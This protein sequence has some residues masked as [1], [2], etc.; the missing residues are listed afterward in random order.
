MTST[1]VNWRQTPSKKHVYIVYHAQSIQRYCPNT[2]NNAYTNT[3]QRL[4]MYTNTLLNENLL[5]F[6]LLSAVFRCP[7]GCAKLASSPG[8]WRLSH[9]ECQNE[10]MK[11]CQIRFYIYIYKYIYNMYIDCIC[12]CLDWLYYIHVYIEYI[13]DYI[14]LYNIC[15]C[16]C[17][18]RALDFASSTLHRTPRKQRKKEKYQETN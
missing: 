9:S 17:K 2:M 14:W 3:A 18:W 15:V 11:N 16:T 6:Q 8:S 1:W 12:T 10:F 13:Y 5:N 4:C 7:A